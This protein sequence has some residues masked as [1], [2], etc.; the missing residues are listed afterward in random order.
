MTKRVLKRC[1]R[2]QSDEVYRDQLVSLKDGID[3]QQT[4]SAA[5]ATSSQRHAT[6]HSADLMLTRD[7]I[8]SALSR[9]EHNLSSTMND[10][11]VAQRSL[12]DGTAT[13]MM[14]SAKA[15]ATEL[16]L[17]RQDV[18]G[19]VGAITQLRDN[20]STHASEL[21]VSS[22]QSR[23]DL[24]RLTDM[25]SQLSSKFDRVSMFQTGPVFPQ[26]V[27]P[28]LTELPKFSMPPGDRV[29]W[30]ASGALLTYL[31]SCMKP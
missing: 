12:I 22:G 9:V 13:N 15:Q 23:E 26:T 27:Q 19:A 5:V 20:V 11:A 10:Y 14:S 7:T 18:G 21:L 3:A 28:A 31:D 1:F 8:G 24:H 4:S 6:A 30:L 2:I 25:V 16:A 17:V 29:P